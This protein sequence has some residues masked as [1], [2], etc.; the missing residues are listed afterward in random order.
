MI[1]KYKSYLK[2]EKNYSPYTILNYI[3]DI[4]EFD[5]YVNLNKFGDL[6]HVNPNIA[7]YY[8]AYL[9]QK[10]FSSRSIARKLCSLRSFYRFLMREGETEV[11]VFG[12]ITAP[13]LER[14][15]PHFLYLEE[16]ESLFSSINTNNVIGKRDYALLELLYGTGM[17]VSEFCNLKLG[18]IDFYNNNL[19][20]M[21]KGSKERYLPI[22]DNIKNTLIDYLEYSR[23]HLLA[24]NKNGNTDYLFLN[25]KGTPLTP[26]GV[27]VILNNLTEKTAEHLKI[28]PHM[29]R[30][31]FATHLLDNGA[32]LRS[33]QELLGHVNLSTTQ[34]Y[35]HVSKEKLKSAYMDFFPRAKRS[36]H[37]ERV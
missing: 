1:E 14:T 11:N 12:E 23:N 29:L 30:H 7:R 3:N 10:G 35:T 8:I 16:I 20:V 26:R 17:R 28:S 13:K 21:G 4:N 31:S 36:D 18:D 9:N 19:I 34:I 27:R 5:N 15:L 24:K 32:D 33:V 37:D 6:L 22:S 2:N 25:Y